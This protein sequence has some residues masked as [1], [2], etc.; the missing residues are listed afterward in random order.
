MACREKRFSHLPKSNFRL[1]EDV[2]WKD[3]LTDAG[4]S[5]DPNP[6][7]REGTPR[8]AA[9]TMEPTLEAYQETEV[10]FG[11]FILVW[12]SNNGA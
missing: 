6:G 4:S 5:H 9:V 1:V 11:I 3:E 7:H 8:D 2:R 12:W 10:L